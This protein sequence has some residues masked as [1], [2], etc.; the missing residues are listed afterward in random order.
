MVKSTAIARLHDGLPL[1]TSVDDSDVEKELASTKQQVKAIIRKVNDKSEPK[2]SIESGNYSIHYIITDNVVYLCIC[3]KSYPRKLAFS[4]LD[5]IQKE[6]SSTYGSEISKPG[7][8]PYAFVQFDSFIQQTRKL[9]QDSRATQNLDKLNTELQDVTRIMTKNIEDLLYRGDNLDRMSHMSSS[10][11][12][13]SK[14]YRRAAVRINF[15][16]LLRQYAPISMLAL[17]FV[18][19]IWYFFLR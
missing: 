16:A 2:A 13:E 18:F 14:K 5:E 10:L 12:D 3:D 1:A 6:F 15:E 9:Y 17:M 11:R 8:R 4:Y 19:F 7:L